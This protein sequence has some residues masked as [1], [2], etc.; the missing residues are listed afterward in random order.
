MTDDSDI[1]I[2]AKDKYPPNE[3]VKINGTAG[4]GKSTQ[5]IDKRLIHEIKRRNLNY[6]DFTVCTYRTSLAEE[7]VNKLKDKNILSK[8]LDPSDTY[9]GT[10]HAVARRLINRSPKTDI[11]VNTL[12]TDQHKQIFLEKYNQT[13]FNNKID[14]SEG[15]V[16]FDLFSYMLNNNIPPENIPQDKI[17]Q[18]NDKWG[19]SK[20]NG[21]TV[22][23]KKIWNDWQEFKDNPPAEVNGNKLWDFDELLLIVREKEIVPPNKFLVVDEMHDAYPLLNDVVQMWINA[24]KNREDATVVIAGDPFQVINEYQGASPEFY[25]N[26]DLPEIVLDTTYRCPQ[27]VWSYA[28]R[29]LAQEFN[30]NNIKS[31][32]NEGIIKELNAAQ[33]DYDFETGTWSIQDSKW[34]P[35]TIINEHK[36]KDNIMFLTRT[37]HQLGGIA[38]QLD[39]QGIIYTGQTQNSWT[40]NIELLHLFNMIKTIQQININD[41]N[42]LTDYNNYTIY[43]FDDSIKITKPRL[44]ALIKY[45]PDKYIRDSGQY[46]NNNKWLNSLNYA[47]SINET[48]FTLK[49]KVF[50][51]PITKLIKQLQISKYNYKRL[52]E[53]VNRYD[54]IIPEKEID[55]SLRT[56]HESK[57]MQAQTV[58][59]Y[60]GIPQ[61]VYKSLQTQSG[62]E[63]ECRTWFVGASRSSYKLLIMREGFNGL[64]KSPY[65]P[66]V[67]NN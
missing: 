5:S 25:E 45:L 66:D 47:F 62:R 39:T 35:S 11:N 14:K 4:T 32:S 43:N 9:I 37:N 52:L 60:D 61:K 10:I 6:L 55:V 19:E 38:D 64:Y 67:K 57:G 42:N 15:E 23:I 20:K 53:A 27:P 18:L 33:F 30:H 44:K 59:L 3:S 49:E 16:L 34:T 29:I 40:E 7:L 17:D 65:L 21:S 13:Y 54:N 58:V 46:G 51:T 22:D 1:P 36:G 48:Y 24:T 8:E 63:N 41:T 2:I 26:T 31:S 50:T 56:I 28:Q 12:V